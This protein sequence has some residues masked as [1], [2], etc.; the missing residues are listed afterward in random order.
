MNIS[1]KYVFGLSTTHMHLPGNA[2]YQVKLHDTFGSFFIIRN[3]IFVYKFCCSARVEESTASIIIIE[4][5]NR[6]KRSDTF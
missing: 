2:V 5:I 3:N 4:N 1:V 6:L